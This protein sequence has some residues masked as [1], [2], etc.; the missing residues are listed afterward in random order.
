MEAEKI[1]SRSCIMS[2]LTGKPLVTLRKRPYDL[3]HIRECE[4]VLSVSPNV[5][6][7]ASA[8]EKIITNNSKWDTVIILYESKLM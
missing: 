3:H 6:S 2:T 5:E 1:S 8:M 7:Y 4:N